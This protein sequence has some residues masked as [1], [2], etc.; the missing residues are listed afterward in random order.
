MR[1]QVT[2][3]AEP[4]D[5]YAALLV[6]HDLANTASR[7]VNI[8]SRVGALFLIT[9]KGDIVQK[10]QLTDIRPTSP[11][12]FT[13]IANLQL[14]AKNEGTVHAIPT[15]TIEIRNIFGFLVDEIP[16][17]N[18]IVLRESIKKRRLEWS[19]RFSLGRYTATT[20]L[21][22][23]DK[24]IEQLSTSFWMIPIIPVTVVVVAIFVVSFLVQ[25]FFSGFEIRRKK[26]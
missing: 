25:Y 3:D 20:K 18:W 15:G 24:P 6:Q 26:H 11:V 14:T 4:G 22:M 2:S 19:P 5:H 12:F 17:E 7:G 21:T 10:A 9:V 13:P 8:V 16:V 1:V 23:F